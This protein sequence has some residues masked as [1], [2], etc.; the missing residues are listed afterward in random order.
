MK[1]TK[2]LALLLVV[3]MCFS[4]LASCNIFGS[5]CEHVDA[6]DNGKCDKCDADFEDGKD[7]IVKDSYT[8]KGYSTALG[9]NWNPHTWETNAD[10]GILSYL[11]MGFASME[12]KDTE[13][14]IYQWVFEMAESIQDVTAANKGDL[15]KYSVTLP[16]G[17]ESYDEV[18]EGFVYEIKLNKDAK[19]ENGEAINA[20][21][22]IESMKRLLSSKYRNYRANLYVSGES[23]VAGGA[24]YFN[25]EAP[26]YESWLTS[27]ESYVS[28]YGVDADGFATVNLNGT[29]H[30]IY[31]TFSG[32]IPFFGSNSMNAYIDAGYADA[33]YFSVPVVEELDLDNLPDYVEVYED[34]V[35]EED[36]D[37]N[38][39][40]DADGNPVY[41]QAKDENGQ[42]MVDEEGN[43]VYETYPVYYVNLATKYADTEDPYGVIKV[44]PTMVE[45]FKYLALIFGDQNPV[46]WNE[47]FLYFT[48]YGDKVEYDAVGC[49]KVDEYTIRYVTQNAI[50]FNNFL[51]SM[52]DTWLVYAPLYDSL[53]KEEGSIL[54]TTY[55]TS[56]D[57][58]MSYG[59]Y[60]MV[61][62]E[63]SK[64]IVFVQNE[65]WYGWE[66]DE[67]GN[68]VSYTDCINALDSETGEL[69]PFHVDGEAQQ[70]HLTTKIVIDV[71]DEA[72]AKQL[73]LKGELS[74]WSPPADELSQYALSDRLYKVDETYTMSF[75]FNND[76]ATLKGLD[77]EGK[78]KNSVVLNNYNFRKAMS[79]AI[80]RAD[81]VSVT[82]GWT[83]AFSTMNHLYYY[84]FFNDP[85]SIYRDS[86]AAMQAIVNLYGVKYGPGELYATLEEAHDS[87]TGFNLTEAK[88]LMKTA[89][90]ELV[91][92]GLY[93]AGEEIKIQIGWA[94]GALQADDNAQVDKLNQYI[95]AAL[96]GS[97]FGKITFEAVGNID[98]RYKDTASGLY[99]I[100]YG[101]WGGAALYP[102]RN[103]Q[104]YCDPSQYN[105]NEAGCWDPTTEE[106][107]LVVNGVED[108]MTWQDWSNSMISGGKY[109]FADN[110]TK[111]YITAQMEQKFLEKY[112]RIPLAVT[113][114]CS[115]LS[116]QMDYYTQT[117]NFA[118]GFGGMRLMSY[119]YTD[120][121]WA[122]YLKTVPNGELNYK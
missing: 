106:L 9:T 48:H 41:V 40:L 69:V 21:T 59:I 42:P 53:T 10:S 83:P 24:A 70:Q 120:A 89:C 18:E 77:A 60:K 34:Y 80:N 86:E 92:A 75:F 108:T 52:T 62:Y 4:M 35:V 105:I 23:A 54:V 93:T 38:P 16:K 65:N 71:M 3:V 57:S 94:K 25:S 78:N 39:V 49:Y 82:Q 110:E 22:Y 121:E 55:G 98:D 104:V 19:W 20:D 85:T 119:N 74:E 87:I 116:F 51:T 90:E 103:F 112:Y 79:L 118:Y 97:G 111:L 95:N 88:A 63:D 31:T 100:G 81:Y 17:F 96:E 5:T 45:E 30:N 68:L 61:T 64:Q 73:F 56:L 46:A 2:I 36:A 117:Y 28:E 8:Y 32:L 26:I 72:A 11:S 67:N 107:T 27:A 6:D 114:V 15:S 115:L 58:T 102:F 91:E 50:D 14:G 7:V 47:F 29:D 33:G 76:L 13:N 37:G 66:E 99:A 122:E 113:T 101:A 109:A 12:A 84:D 1:S 43:P 44:T